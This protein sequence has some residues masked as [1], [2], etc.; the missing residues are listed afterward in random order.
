[1][2]SLTFHFSE[3]CVGLGAANVEWLPNFETSES[4]SAREQITEVMVK[5]EDRYTHPRSSIEI[6]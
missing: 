5:H 6:F 3:F 1:M 4:L 2:D